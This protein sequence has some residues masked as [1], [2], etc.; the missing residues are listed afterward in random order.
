M[1]SIHGRFEESLQSQ[2]F[3]ARHGVSSENRH[4]RLD[5]V[6]YTVQRLGFFQYRVWKNVFFPC[7]VGR[8]V[9]GSVLVRPP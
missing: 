9:Q 4:V 8:D 5:G 6:C 1:G 3:G 2:A 7:K